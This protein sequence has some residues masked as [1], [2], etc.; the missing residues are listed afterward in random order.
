[1]SYKIEKEA[2]GCGDNKGPAS[3]SFRIKQY[4]ADRG[5]KG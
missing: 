4:M 5:M 1:M 3:S 2:A